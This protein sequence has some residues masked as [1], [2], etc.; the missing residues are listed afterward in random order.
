MAKKTLKFSYL[1]MVL[2]MMSMPIHAERNYDSTPVTVFP[3]GEDERTIAGSASYIGDEELKNLV[4][5]T[6]R[7]SL[8][9]YLVFIHKLKMV[10]V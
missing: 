3:S 10:S 9:G 2:F 8:T 1:W 5:Q 4:T 7:E 6:L